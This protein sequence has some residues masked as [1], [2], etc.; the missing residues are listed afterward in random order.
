M[1]FE[2]NDRAKAI[3]DITI[4]AIAIGTKLLVNSKFSRT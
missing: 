3:T 1:S 2:E 4:A